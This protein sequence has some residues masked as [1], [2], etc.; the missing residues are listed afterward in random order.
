MWLR[1][2]ACQAIDPP[3]SPTGFAPG[4][5]QIDPRESRRDNSQTLVDPA[6]ILASAALD[7]E[8]DV[9]EPHPHPM[10]SPLILASRSPIRARLLEA[11]GVEVDVR[12]AAVDEAAVTE[13]LVAEGA[14]PRDIAGAL[15]EMKARRITA[16]VPGTPVLGADQVL[17]CEGRLL[18]KPGDLDAAAAQ[19][20]ALRG[21][22]HELLSAAV[23]CR[24]GEPVWRHVG[25]AQ[26]VMRPFSEAF[27]ADYLA[28]EGPGITECVGAYRLEGLGAQL[29][30]RVQGDYFT[31]LGLPLLELL[32]YLRTIGICRE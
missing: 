12:P 21:R 25:R 2:T 6:A 19:L 24:D 10:L 15:A 5:P 14:P 18:D 31:V 32:G 16:S 29:F 1:C 11:A 7:G 23:I 26:L 9:H 22:S 4:F 8:T 20:R 13:A 27:L 17:V 3:Q 28:A 30:S